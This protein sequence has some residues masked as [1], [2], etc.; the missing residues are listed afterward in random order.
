MKKILIPILLICTFLLSGCSATTLFG[1]SS[2]EVNNEYKIG[3]VV[4][5]TDSDYYILIIA[6]ENYSGYDESDNFNYVGVY[7]PIGGGGK[8]SCVFINKDEITNKLFSLSD[9]QSEYQNNDIESL[10]FLPIGT[11]VK[12]SGYEEYF[13]II[14]V[15][16]K[17]KYNGEWIP[18]DYSA[19]IYPQGLLYAGDT[20]G[21][22]RNSIEE[23]IHIGYDTDESRNYSMMMYNLI[24]DSNGNNL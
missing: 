7:Y 3:D 12:V 13:M 23:V 19:V 10:P 15:G 24:Q 18:C 2:K 16:Q 11:V 4:N 5:I 14:G 21:I 9:K 22:D 8:D 20:Y 1:G 6:D 17:V